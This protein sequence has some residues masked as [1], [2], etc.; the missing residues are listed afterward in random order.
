[1]IW[2]TRNGNSTSHEFQEAAIPHEVNLLGLELIGWLQFAILR[3]AFRGFMWL[4][5]TIDPG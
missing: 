1:M 3:A 2:E 5:V 4:T